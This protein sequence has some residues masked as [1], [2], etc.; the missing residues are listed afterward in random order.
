MDLHDLLSKVGISIALLGV[1][2]AAIGNIFAI[3]GVAVAIVA[4]AS[5][6]QAIS[7]QK[8]RLK[9]TNRTKATKNRLLQ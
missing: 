2:V 1:A 5:V 8:I 3:V 9:R 7:A 6:L 4:S